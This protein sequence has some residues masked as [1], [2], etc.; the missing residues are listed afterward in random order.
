MVQHFNY[1]QYTGGNIYEVAKF[2]IE[3]YLYDVF[4]NFRF[5]NYPDGSECIEIAYFGVCGWKNEPYRENL[6]VSKGDYITNL[7]SHRGV[8][9]LSKEVFEE[10]FH[11]FLNKLFFLNEK[12]NTL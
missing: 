1:V 5:T 7:I 8:V 3:N 4:D 9:I 10:T 6:F 12:N 2:C 11:K